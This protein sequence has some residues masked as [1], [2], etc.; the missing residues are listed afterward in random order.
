MITAR[1]I[2]GEVNEAIQEKVELS[3]VSAREYT[4]LNGSL[5]LFGHVKEPQDLTELKEMIDSFDIRCPITWQVNVIAPEKWDETIQ[6]LSES[7][8]SREATA[9][10]A[11]PL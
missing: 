7:N 9:E 8:K 1:A 3:Y 6:I 10:A 2:A 11:P 5:L 4:G